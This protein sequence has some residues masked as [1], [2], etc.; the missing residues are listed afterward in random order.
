MNLFAVVFLWLHLLGKKYLIYLHLTNL[1]EAQLGHRHTEILKG[2]SLDLRLKDKQDWEV[3]DRFK[4]ELEKK[5]GV[6]TKEIKG[7]TCYSTAN[8]I[9][10]RHRRISRYIGVKKENS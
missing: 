1:T 4:E 5:G 6:P 3:S 9:T 7:A 8:H 2:I 10:H